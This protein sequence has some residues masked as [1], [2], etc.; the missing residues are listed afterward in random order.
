MIQTEGKRRER[1]KERKKRGA[2]VAFKKGMKTTPSVQ[3][4]PNGP[5]AFSTNSEGA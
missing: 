3:V 2:P 4:Y 1:K 5:S